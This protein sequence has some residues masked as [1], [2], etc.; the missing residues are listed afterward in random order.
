MWVI[1]ML[2]VLFV[3]G[4]VEY[5]ICFINMIYLCLLCMEDDFEFDIDILLERVNFYGI[6]MGWWLGIIGYYIWIVYIYD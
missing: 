6:V 2:D 3:D 1:Y 4:F 5:S